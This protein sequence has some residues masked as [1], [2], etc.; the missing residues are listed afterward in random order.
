MGKQNNSDFDAFWENIYINK[1]I[2]YAQP[3]PKSF[4]HDID[5]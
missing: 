3:F 4:I 5:S 2:K 1:M